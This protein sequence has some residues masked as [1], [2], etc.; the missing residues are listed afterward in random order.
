MKKRTVVVSI[1]IVVLFLALT[2]LIP[3][4]LVAAEKN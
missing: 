2:T 4:G 3:S 1:G